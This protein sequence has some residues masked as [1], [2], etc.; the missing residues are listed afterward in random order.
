[1]EKQHGQSRT[2]KRERLIKTKLNP[3]GAFQT[4][5]PRRRLSGL[6]SLDPNPY[7][8]VLVTAPAGYGK[9]TLLTQWL[10]VLEDQGV[11]SGWLSLDADDNDP[12]RFVTYVFGALRAILEASRAGMPTPDKTGWQTAVQ[13]LL[14]SLARELQELDQPIALFLDDYNCICD[15]AVHDA[16]NWL[17]LHSPRRMTF[18][19]ASRSEPPIALSSLRLR[20]E[21]LELRLE[22]LSF[23]LDEAEHFL[24]ALKGH[25]L[26]RTELSGLVER[27]EGWI[28]G[29]SLVSLALND[30]RDLGRLIREFSGS[31]RAI[32]DYLGEAVL[33]RL[34]PQT[35]DFLLVTSVLD[36]M[37]AD[38]C[39]KITG[40][41]DCQRLLEQIEAEN[42][43]LLPLDRE[44]KWYRYHHLFADFLHTR[45]AVQQPHRVRSCYQVASEWFAEHGYVSEAIRYAFL[46]EDFD[47]VGDLIE[48]TWEDLVERRGEHATLLDWMR[49]LPDAQVDV[50]P[51]LRVAHAWSLTLTRQYKR[52]ERELEKLDASPER[53]SGLASRDPAALRAVEMIR[54]VLYALTDQTARCLSASNAWLDRWSDAPWFEIGSV[55]ST[56]AYTCVTRRKFEQGRAALRRA[57]TAF[58]SCYG[59]YGIAWADAMGGLLLMDESRPR[60]ATAVYR[61]G[62]AAAERELGPCSYGRSMLSTLLAEALYEQDELDEARVHLEAGFPLVDEHG[63]VETAQAGYVTRARLL[64]HEGRC[65][66]MDLGLIDGCRL[67]ERLGLQRLSTLLAAERISLEL[68]CGEVGKA[69]AIAQTMGFLGPQTAKP[70]L[71]DSDDATRDI[72]QLVRARLWTASGEPTRAVST[73]GTLATRL[74]KRGWNRRLLELLIVRTIAYERCGNR[75]MAL[76]ALDTGVRLA[77]SGGAVRV[78]L[79]AGPVIGVLLEEM[80]DS[81]AQAPGEDEAA[82]RV[83]LEKLTRRVSP[84]AGEVT[85]TIEPAVDG[86]RTNILTRRETEILKLLA[87]GLSNHELAGTLFVSETTVKWHLSNLY[88]K[89]G[90][91]NRTSAVDHGRQHSLI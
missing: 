73:L 75:K 26:E 60:D 32:T 12:V 54:C 53:K 55:C 57:R 1:M 42:L 21:L 61:H 19:I 16:L 38:L 70:G 40:R 65:E 88:A 63:V 35:R 20:G 86:S 91:R 72:V 2:T 68:R 34:G 90:V 52:A 58:E 49:R 80:S 36:R 85:E 50:R 64:C 9:S 78:F 74:R 81:R 31:D 44:H 46:A 56:L 41:D 28:A 5:V 29:L 10:G 14:M 87:K 33:S 18:I 47:R 37:C 30:T 69:Y 77:A 13:P 43:F 45:L 67:G 66:E 27:T 6:L 22:D 39:G 24:N 59:Y 62:L 17:I 51:Q 79:D 89:L 4:V 7:K 84:V 71:T 25:G 8:L 23:Q 3:P 15:Q 48:N 82:I 83:L 11:A 76:R